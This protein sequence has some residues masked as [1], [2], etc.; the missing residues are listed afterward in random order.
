MGDPASWC[1][2]RLFKPPT[3]TIIPIQSG[4]NSHSTF[5]YK[6]GVLCPQLDVPRN[7]QKSRY[8]TKC[9][10]HKD[11]F[12]K[13]MFNL[14]PQSSPFGAI[15]ELRVVLHSAFKMDYFLVPNVS[16]VCSRNPTTRISTH[17][18]QTVRLS[19]EFWK[20]KLMTSKELQ[21]VRNSKLK[22]IKRRH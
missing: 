11:F 6:I 12:M 17:S 9:T 1:Q 21:L 19:W 16:S 15:W 13:F 4:T 10:T 18:I 3:T 5:N 2:L 8:L 7:F 20:Y 14:F 22:P